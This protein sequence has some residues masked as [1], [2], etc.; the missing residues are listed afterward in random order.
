M[1][2]CVIIQVVNTCNGFG[3]DCDSLTNFGCTAKYIKE[4]NLDKLVELEQVG[5]LELSS[6]NARHAI[7]KGHKHLF[8]WFEKHRVPFYYDGR[9]FYLRV[10][11]TG[12]VSTHYLRKLENGS[13]VPCYCT[14]EER[15]YRLGHVCESRTKIPD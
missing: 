8:H 7:R 2:F 1:L 13:F 15:E 5:R 4:G 12:D 14:E 11:E 10:G 3:E 6:N 9:Y